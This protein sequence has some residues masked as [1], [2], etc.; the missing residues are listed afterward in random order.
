MPERSP[1][2]EAALLA[3]LARSHR[4]E[5]APAAPRRP[6][7]LRAAAWAPLA[8]MGAA[9][10]VWLL[11]RPERVTP[12]REPAPAPSAARQISLSGA[13]VPGTL[14]WRDGAA[15]YD[16][17]ER[18][19]LYRFSLQ[20]AGSPAIEVHWKQCTFPAELRAHT[21]RLSSPSSGELRVSVTGQWLEPGRLEASELHVL[22]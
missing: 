13:A 11:L 5:A 3:R 17:D 12:L 19:C 22:P 10:L 18:Q 21:Q 6:R 9:A 7:P 4:S 15:G 20:P 1:S 14:R 2:P 8:A 16:T